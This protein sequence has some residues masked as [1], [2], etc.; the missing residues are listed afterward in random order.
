MELIM[1]QYRYSIAECWFFT[2]IEAFLCDAFRGIAFRTDH[3]IW[4]N[5][6]FP[7]IEIYHEHHCMGSQGNSTDDPDADH[8]LFSGAGIE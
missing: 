1:E 4:L 8:L 3:C 5:V 2:D 6:T 7:A